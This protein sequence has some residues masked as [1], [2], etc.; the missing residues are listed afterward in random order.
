MSR[1]AE[2]SKAYGSDLSHRSPQ[3]NDCGKIEGSLLCA[4]RRREFKVKLMEER[5]TYQKILNPIKQ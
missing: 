4:G 2:A 1:R 5:A 3:W